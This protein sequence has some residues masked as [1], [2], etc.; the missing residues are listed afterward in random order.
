M[1]IGMRGTVIGRERELAAL[2]RAFERGESSSTVVVIEGEPGVGKSTLW[3]QGIELAA[4][5]GWRVL[6]A[7]AVEVETPL[8][9]ATL[10]DLVDRHLDDVAGAFPFRSGERCR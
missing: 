3:Q 6:S 8:G 9:Y 10:T 7:R 4:K 2:G 1:L 5:R